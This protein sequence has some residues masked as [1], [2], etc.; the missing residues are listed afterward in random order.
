MGEAPGRP[1]IEPRWTSSAKSGIGT[2][3]SPISR[4]WFTLSHGILNEIYYPRVD[5]ACTRDLG[6]IVTDDAGFFAEEKR[7]C[8][9]TVETLEDGVPAYRLTST[10]TG[11]RFRIVKR[12]ISD[13]RADVVLQHI[14]LEDL[15]GDGGL[16]LFA[17][18][19]PHLVN[20]G[21]H[22]TGWVG[23]YKGHRMLFARGDA[24]A[25]A[26]L[27]MAADRPFLACSAGFVGASDGWQELHRNQHLATCYDSATDGNVALTAELGL[28]PDAPARLAVGFGAT[29]AEAGFRVRASLQAPFEALIEEYAAGW[30]GWQAT[31]RSLDRRPAREILREHNQTAPGDAAQ[32]GQPI[33]HNLYRVSTAVLRCH[34][35]PTFPGGLIAGLSIPWGF[36]KGDDDMGGYH[37]VW[38]RDLCETGGALLACGAEAEALRVLRYLRATQEADGS[39][40]QNCWLDGRPYWRGIQLDECAF[41]LLLTDMAYR[42]GVLRFPVLQVF[43]PMVRAAAGYLLRTGPKTG[44]DRWEENAGYTPFTLAVEIAALLAAADLAELCGIEG[45][46]GLLRET[47]DAWNEQIEDWIYVAGTPLAAETGVAGYYVR[48]A[49][50]RPEDACPDPHGTVVVRNRLGDGRVPA[51]ELIS[52]DALALVRFGLRAPDDPR[53]TCTVRVIDHVLRAD[54]PQGPGWRRYNGDGYGEKA[55]GEAFDG[56]GIG[57]VWPLLAGERAHYELAAGRRAEAE[58]LLAVIEAQTSPGGLMPEQ[59]WDAAPIPEAELFPGQP[60]G[61]AMPLAWAHAEYIKL[62]R[63]LADGAVFDLPPQTVKRY[64]H[65]TQTAR[66]RP[67]RPDWSPDRMPAGKVLRLDLPEPSVAVWTRDGW[68]TLAETATCDSGFDLHIAEIPTDGMRAGETL[69]FTWRNAETGAW[70]GR[71]HAVALW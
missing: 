43:W 59:V 66:C 56:T 68:A 17:L 28:S 15:S 12:V 50:G 26:A 4:V 47:A 7:D 48:V 25:G 13:P 60:S 34:E 9:F 42:Q 22:N 23:D 35:S 51:D 30:R 2:A 29:D 32:P 14:S 64:L 21:A 8:T 62:L 65:R 10:H 16:R 54:L 41:P 36:A 58:R 27:A 44:Q 19:S 52:T 18:L 39:W 69:V 1:V 5:Q 20:G 6:L 67:W 37:L 46:A 31:L 53:I 49:P 63:S 38:P 33:G 45:V 70:T 11:G 3:L 24:T 61:S 71:D 55:D 40:P 57:R